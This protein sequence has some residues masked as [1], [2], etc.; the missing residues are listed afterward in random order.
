MARDFVLTV[1]SLD[2]VG[3]VADMTAAITRLAGNIDAISQ[4]VM[5]GYFTIIVTVHFDEEVNPDALARAV[6]ESG[7]PG[8][9]EVSVKER[10]VMQPKP[11]VRDAERF[12]LTI[13]GPDRKGIIH[14]ITT[15]LASRN[16]NLEDLYA[17]SEGEGFVLIAQ[18]QVPTGMPI[19]RLQMDVE[20]LWSPGEMR[21][22]LQHENVFLATNHVDF[23]REA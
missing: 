20:G 23:R 3:I 17:Y 8:E 10:T 6:R 12:I 22:S 14:R 16:V 1:M 2:R 15:F 9:L 18:L 7:S 5:Q 11:V 19:E 13:T 4:T 21:V